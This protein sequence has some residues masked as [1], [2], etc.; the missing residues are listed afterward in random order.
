MKLS[1][2]FPLYNEQK[3]IPKLL[4]VLEEF[5][6]KEKDFKLEIVFVND[7]STDQ[8]E[9][10]IAEFSNKYPQSTKLVSYPENK[11]KGYAVRKGMLQSSGDWR[12]LMDADLA[13]DLKEIDRIRPLLNQGKHVVIGS[14]AVDGSVI[15]KPQ[16]LARVFLGKGFTFFANAVSILNVS[17]FTCGFKAFPKEAVETF[18]LKSQI[19]RWAYDV[20][21]LYL[22]K[23]HGFG[24]K[25]AGVSWKNG[26]ET[27]V[28]FP[29]DLIQSFVDLFRIVIIHG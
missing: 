29:K 7:G 14:R 18:F 12:I 10:M 25:E 21:L 8:T 5:F 13:V 16:G 22:A 11:G 17:D 19:D 24:I 23:K 15:L 6:A 2:V 9:V 27:K 1:I 26:P 28:K 4:L 3:N 20:E